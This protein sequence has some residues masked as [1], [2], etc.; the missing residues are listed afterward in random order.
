VSNKQSTPGVERRR[1]RP[2]P[3]YKDSGVRWLA[4][5][6]A[7]W[8]ICAV[9]H[10]FDIFLGKMLQPEPASAH[11]LQVPY[12]K[13]ANVQWEN[14]GL[15][16]LQ[17]MWAS[18]DE[19]QTGQVAMGDL[20]VCEGGEVG[21]AAILTQ[22]PEEP[23]IIQN[24]LH[25]VR[26]QSELPKFLMYLL[27]VS[28]SGRW[29]EVE[30]NKA[31]IQHFTRDKFGSLRIALPSLDEQCRIVSFLDRETAK[32][33]ALIEKKQQLIELLQEKRTALIT[34][35][36]TKGLD[37][38]VPR[39]DSGVEWIERIPGSWRV[40]PLFAAAREKEKRNYGNQVQ[41][42]LSLSYGKIIDK[43]VS[44]NF[45]L[46]PESFETYQIV[47]KGNIILRLTDLQNDKRSLRVGLVRHQGIITSAYICLDF[48]RD[49]DPSY[50]FYLLHAYDITK[51][52][53]GLG[54]GVRQTMKFEDLKWLP[55]LMPSAAEQQVIASFLDREATKIDALISRIREA[56]TSLKEYRTALIFAAVTGKMDVREVQ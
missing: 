32:F 31:T 50:A 15:N 11:D 3:E 35:A 48:F 33:D 2:Y 52:F 39:K 40:C 16:S 46:L 5:V 25:R 13:A 1:F 43:D 24:A 44:D 28:A 23:T 54:G 9:K 49:I 6:P 51:V 19:I 18:K 29:L 22:K 20:L 10:R 12:L 42:V 17:T 30:C 26:S 14:I 4:T 37:P 7:S 8:R 53:Y 38:T 36:V 27:E 45:G 41:N 47:S 34:Q 56:I 21:R 55:I